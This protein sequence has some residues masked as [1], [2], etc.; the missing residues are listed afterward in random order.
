M[1]Y[2]HG[3]TEAEVL[4]AVEQVVEMLCHSFVFGYYELEDVQQEARIMALQALPKYD[5][6]PDADGK[7]TR[8]LPNF[9]YTVVRTRL[10]NLRRDKYK[11]NDPP[12]LLCHRGEHATH[13]DGQPCKAYRSWKRRNNTKAN[14]ARPQLLEAGDERLLKGG[15]ASHEI[16][17]A[18]E[19]AAL[20]DEKLPVSLR[21][22][23]LRVKAGERIPKSRR[24]RVLAA[25]REIVCDPSPE[26]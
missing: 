6:R 22:D 12:C 26:N 23:Y 19:L 16:A 13:P 8:P 4:A 5:P 24:A 2:P 20:I 3:L 7:T 21:A 9:L 18:A 1:T 14:L 25:I 17:Q 15:E 11:R 10:I